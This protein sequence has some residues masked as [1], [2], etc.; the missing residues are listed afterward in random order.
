M[1]L[2]TD[3]SNSWYGSRADSWENG[4]ETRSYIQFGDILTIRAALTSIHGVRHHFY[5]RKSIRNLFFVNSTKH[6]ASYSLQLFQWTRVTI[7]PITCSSNTTTHDR[8]VTGFI[9]AVTQR[10]E[11]PQWTQ[12]T[13]RIQSTRLLTQ[14]LQ[15]V[16]HE[17]I[18]IREMLKRIATKWVIV[19]VCTRAC[20]WVCVRAP[21]I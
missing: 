20:A 5:K 9:V 15:T 18:G 13:I 12:E 16:V 4:N 3:S 17:P 1:R 14:W 21:C 2:W 6:N 19:F 7:K 8:Q 11:S 10:D